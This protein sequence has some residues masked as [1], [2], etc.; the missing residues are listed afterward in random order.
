M[1]TPSSCS[2]AGQQSCVV[3]GSFYA[4]ELCVINGSACYLSAYAVTSQ[5]LRALDFDHITANAHRLRAGTS[6]GGVAGTLNDC[7]SNNVQ[8]CVTDAT[9][10]S[11]DLTNLSPGNIKSGVSIAGQTGDYPSATYPLSGSDG[12]SDLSESLATRESQLRSASSFEFFTSDGT[13]V[14]ANGDADITAGNIKASIDIFGVTGTYSGLAPS[15]WDLR[16]GITAG[17]VTGKLKTN[18][19]N[20]ANLS[21]FDHAEIP[22]LATLDS[23]TDTVTITSHGRSNNQTVRF[24]AETL[25]TGLSESTTYYVR[26]PTANTFQI[27]TSSGGAA[28]DFTTNGG[29]VYFYPPGGSVAQEWDTIDD[30]LG[31]ANVFPASW[32]SAT[33]LCGGIET[34]ADDSNVWKDVTTTGDGTTSSNCATTAA[35][36]SF[37]DKITGLEWHKPDTTGRTWQQALTFCHNLTYNGR[38]D[39]RLPV[40]KELMAAYHNGIAATAG[41]T[42]W[43]TLANMRVGYWSS[44]SNGYGPPTL[45]YPWANSLWIAYG[46]GGNSITKVSNTYRTMCIRP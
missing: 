16:A 8:N 19:R 36:C 1:A 41:A 4:G 23:A 29:Q 46:G 11:A 7:T 26:N 13:R 28:V 22:K 14:V 39:W 32:N 5:P 9:Y 43:I 2:T 35:H 20:G 42:N 33:S 21:Q 17:D 25:P 18:C 31:L 6:I 3:S 40:Q 34:V 37:R 24:Y 38:T 10:R 12:T 27:S 44:T 15:A 45:Y 30:N